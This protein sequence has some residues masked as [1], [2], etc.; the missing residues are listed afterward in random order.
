[1]QLG[2]RWN[3]RNVLHDLPK[4]TTILAA[5]PYSYSGLRR[6]SPGELAET[7]QL[8]LDPQA[9]WTTRE[10]TSVRL[11]P[12]APN[13]YQGRTIYVSESSLGRAFDRL[14][15]LMR[16]NNVSRET[17]RQER[18]E[19]KGYKRRRL[20]SE[21][22]RRRFAHEVRRKVQIVNEIRARGA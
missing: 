11:L 10:A 5:R 15:G 13:A 12:P 2:S 17:Y 21:R 3:V 20:A 16:Q 4:P 19:K 8:D 7:A 14:N 22:W 9:E 18:H 6:L 1:M